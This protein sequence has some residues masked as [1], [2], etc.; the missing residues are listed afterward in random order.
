MKKTEQHEEDQNG[1]EDSNLFIDN[2]ELHFGKEIE[3]SESKSKP[4]EARK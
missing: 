1:E 3:N 4:K 2:G